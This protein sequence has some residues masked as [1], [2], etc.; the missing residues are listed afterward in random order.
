MLEG[1]EREV[2][3]LRGVRLERVHQKQQIDK[4]IPLMVGSQGFIESHT[5]TTIM[6]PPPLL[7]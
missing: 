1:L 4:F 3:E 7:N 5:I 6:P 2:E